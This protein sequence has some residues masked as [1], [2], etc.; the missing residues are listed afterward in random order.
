[1]ANHCVSV[2]HPEIQ[3]LA[4]IT[5]LHPAIVAAKAAIWQEKNNTLDSFPKASDIIKP[6]EIKFSLRSAEILVSDKAKQIFEKGQKNNWTLDKI[7]SELQIPKEQKQLILDLQDPTKARLI[8]KG[9]YEKDLREQIITDLLANYS[10]TVEIN[11]AKTKEKNIKESR[12]GVN[13]NIDGDIY[14][15]E[16]TGEVDFDEFGGSPVIKYTKN[17]KVITEEEFLKQRDKATG[18]PSQ[19]YSNLTVPGGTNYTENEISTPLIIPS[20]KGHAQFSTDN[21]I[22]WFRSDDKT[23]DNISNIPLS[24]INSVTRVD[25]NLRSETKTRRILELQSDLYQKSRDIKSPDEIIA[26]LQKE[27]KLKIDC[28]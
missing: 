7:L 28:N 2:S 10:Y 6:S 19:Y 20:I 14:R 21:G 12:D 17:G 26:Q 3:E 1:M 27:G 9:Y 23:Q 13:F 11:T 15:S 8:P 5:G 25:D 4:N 16:F 22:G 18:K 24:D